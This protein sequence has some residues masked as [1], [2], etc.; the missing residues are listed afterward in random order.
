MPALL[1]AR[2][3]LAALTAVALATALIAVALVASASLST[4]MR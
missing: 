3:A 4:Q 2:R 1:D